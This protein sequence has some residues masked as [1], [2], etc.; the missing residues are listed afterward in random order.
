MTVDEV[1]CFF[2]SV[3]KA[4]DFYGL[5]KEAVYMWRTRP[6]GLIPKG[7]A[8]EAAAFSPNELH[9]N[10]ELY[11]KKSK[12]RKGEKLIHENQSTD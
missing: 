4:A 5:T 9:Y 2:G 3:G 12:A 11:P 1:V 6:G 7:R 10:P 8:I